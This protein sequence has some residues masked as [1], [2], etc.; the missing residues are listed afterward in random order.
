M[1]TFTTRTCFAPEFRRHELYAL[2]ITGM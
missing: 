1:A 2:P